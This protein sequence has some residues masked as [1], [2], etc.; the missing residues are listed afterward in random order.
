MPPE[1]PDPETIDKQ[2]DQ[3]VLT[4]TASQ[5]DALV[6]GITAYYK[7]GSDD[8][9]PSTRLTNVQKNAIKK[10]SAEHFGYISEFNRNVGEQI[11]DKSRDLLK[12][13]KGYKEISEEVKQY[14]ED[15]F[16]GNEKITINNVGKTRKVIEVGKDGTLRKVEKTITRPYVTN[17]QAYSDMLSRTATHTAWE[18]GRA[19]EYQRM[20]F[21]FWRYVCVCDSRSRA[22]HCALSGSVFEYG[23]PESDMAFEM[24]H[25]P[26]CRCRQ[27]IYFSDDELDTPPSVFEEMKK[28]AG[29]E[30]DEEK[31]WIFKTPNPA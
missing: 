15:V 24:M 19:S 2:V 11:K 27:V 23:T 16:S 28:N 20:G 7:A 22:D 9:R 6:A 4:I 21:K 18:Q 29:L 30:Y 14:A 31:G 26:N 8:V 17:T 10:L 3:I 12:Q 13:E 25:S 1:L 5:S